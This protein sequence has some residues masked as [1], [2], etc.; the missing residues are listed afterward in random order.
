MTF[1]LKWGMS[2]WDR[3]GKA[4]CELPFALHHQQPENYTQH[5]VSRL[6]QPGKISVDAH[7]SYPTKAITPLN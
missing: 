2:L 1:A 7:V 6:P 3:N 4:F 5:T